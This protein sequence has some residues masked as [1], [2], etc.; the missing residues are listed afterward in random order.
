MAIPSPELWLL[1]ITSMI[2]GAGLH[3]FLKRGTH[4]CRRKPDDGLMTAL[5]RTGIGYVRIDR[6]G[7][8]VSFN[9]ALENLTGLNGDELEKQRVAS[10]FVD[11][12]LSDSGRLIANI[13]FTPPYDRTH[14]YAL[15]IVH[16]NGQRLP[17]EI[18][19]AGEVPATNGQTQWLI[20][21]ISQ[22]RELE[23]LRLSEERYKS[24][25][26][27]ANIGTWDWIVGTDELHWSEEVAP[28]FGLPAGTTPSY[29]LFC[30]AVHPD[31][32]QHVKDN[33]NACIAQNLKH[34]VEYRVV[35]PDG[36]VRWLRET[37]NLLRDERGGLM[38][39]IGAVR[40][41][42]E[43]KELEQ[44]YQ[45]MAYHDPL[46]G[47]PNRG[48][49]EQRLDLAVQR[50][51]R[52]HANTALM[53]ID[54]GKFKSIN[55][56]YGHVVGDEVLVE[57]GSRLKAA[58]RA[59]DTVARI[60]GDEFVLIL[61]DLKNLDEAENL[62]QKVLAAFREPMEILGHSLAIDLSIGISICPDN[63]AS[64]HELIDL[65]DKAMYAAKAAGANQVRTA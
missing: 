18:W 40:D 42:T 30:E 60:G 21:D 62:A 6:H 64:A 61:E 4:A 63:A 59:T 54:L 41:I 33:E 16:K 23:R 46:T 24:S 9:A 57:A 26:T 3:A 45:H 32:R 35:W 44:R 15:S 65:A 31:D 1:I 5:E 29:S 43:Q 12:E 14:S 51:T 55:D 22:S 36:T 17:V 11:H 37:G 38:R 13:V 50:A 25:R 48:L 28:M 47:L 39:M 7:E 34:D 56:N 52:H 8:L 53:F 10:L 19:F 58:V 2:L 27:F 49:F 20:H